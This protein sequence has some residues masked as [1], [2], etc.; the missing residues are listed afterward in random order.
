ML[1]FIDDYV[2]EVG[3]VFEVTNVVNLNIP[4]IESAFE[5]GNVKVLY[6]DFSQLDVSD[7]S[8]KLISLETLTYLTESLPKGLVIVNCGFRDAILFV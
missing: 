3:H 8:F 5:T 7:P 2:L 4:A 6:Y 1:F